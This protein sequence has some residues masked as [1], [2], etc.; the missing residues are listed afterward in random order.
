MQ[1]KLALFKMVS[2]EFYPELSIL[3]NYLFWKT[4]SRLKTDN[5]EISEPIRF[6]IRKQPYLRHLK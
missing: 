6:D 5:E 4:G 2:P 3:M 1:G